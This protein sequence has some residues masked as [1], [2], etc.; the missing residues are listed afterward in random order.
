ML[1]R[2]EASACVVPSTRLPLVTL[3]GTPASAE[4]S[5]VN[6]PPGARQDGSVVA[7]C[8]LGSALLGDGCATDGEDRRQE[9]EDPNDL[10]GLVFAQG[11]EYPL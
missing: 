5:T 4:P 7:A 1:K 10:H 11:G 2:P 6:A 3:T 8:E 9:D